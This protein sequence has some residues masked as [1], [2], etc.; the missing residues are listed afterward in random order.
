MFYF[1][2]ISVEI[3]PDIVEWC[4]FISDFMWNNL[5]CECVRLLVRGRKIV[6]SSDRTDKFILV[7]K[8]SQLGK[9]KLIKAKVNFSTCTLKNKKHSI[10]LVTIV[11]SS[12]RVFT[13]RRARSRLDSV[14]RAYEPHTN[15]AM[16]I[17]Y[18]IKKLAN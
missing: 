12:T 5:C 14:W 13:I 10:R 7:E 6:V 8:E 9:F 17:R 1:L 4:T 11:G 2:F 3:A 16:N 18:H 15:T